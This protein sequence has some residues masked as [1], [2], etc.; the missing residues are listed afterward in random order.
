MSK[1]W[2]WTS[3][4]LVLASAGF[5]LTPSTAEAQRWGGRGGVRYGVG[6]YP[7]YGGYGSGYG[8]YGYGGYYSG[9]GYYPRYYS[10]YY[11]PSYSYSSYPQ[12]Y[13]EPSMSYYSTVPN[14]SYY[15][16]APSTTYESQL[17]APAEAATTRIQV[18]LPA[19]DAEVWIAGKRMSQSGMDRNFVSPALTP[20]RTYTYEVRARWTTRDGQVAEQNRTVSFRAGETVNVD[21]RV[22]A[23]SY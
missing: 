20:G 8:G 19:P 17:P 6:G 14:T 1:N 13:V 5:W 2:L 10:S 3:V 11:Y 23:A 22:A 12:Y 18:H 15:S 16:P 4:V 7:Y 21:F 9:Y